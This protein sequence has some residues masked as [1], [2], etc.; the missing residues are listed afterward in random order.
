MVVQE[1]AANSDLWTYDLERGTPSKFTFTAGSEYRPVW[2]PEGDQIIFSSGQDGP[3]NLFRKAS[4]GSGEMEPLKD[5]PNHQFATSFS[6]DGQTLVFEVLR[7]AVSN[8][9]I[10][11]LSLMVLDDEM[12]IESLLATE[13]DE[14]QG[15]VSPDGRWLAYVSDQSGQ[16]EVYVRSFADVAGGQQQIS[17]GGGESPVWARDGRELFYARQTPDGLM[18]LMGV[19]VESGVI[20]EAESPAILLEGAYVGPSLGGGLSYDVAPDGE[21]FLMLKEATDDSAGVP[22]VVVLNW[23]EELKEL[24]PTN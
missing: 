5:S 3:W 21:R 12:S 22:R 8:L 1:D 17:T 24:V 16:R 6:P 23:H 19:A 7:G 13:F 14:L 10:F 18:A 4:N 9:G 15:S 20:L 11:D 2:S